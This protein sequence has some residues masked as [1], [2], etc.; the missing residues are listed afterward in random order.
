MADN[1]GILGQLSQ[2]RCIMTSET[3]PRE[4]NEPNR[5]FAHLSALASSPLPVETA[6]FPSPA[7]YIRS[8]GRVRSEEHWEV[9]RTFFAPM[10]M[11]LIPAA[12]IAQTLEVSV[13]TVG[14]WKKRL[15][16]DM[17]REAVTMQPRDFIMESIE[18]LREAR[19]EAWK[20]YYLSGTPR[21]RRAF[22]QSITQI[23]GQLGKLGAD[24]GLYGGRGDKPLS[25]A[26]HGGTDDDPTA[27]GA[28]RI[29]FF[30]EQF[31]SG[32]ATKDVAMDQGFSGNPEET[33]VSYD[34]LLAEPRPRQPETE[35]PSPTP[36]LPPGITARRRQRQPPPLLDAAP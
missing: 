31:L 20:G 10:V 24:N 22:L 35:P 21:D 8:F 26:T 14:R 23:E 11:Q 13:E 30:L 12:E 2:D 19:A 34:A 29:K 4:P 17:R 18:S 5:A 27:A 36:Q 15:F 7:A 16:A 6:L 32:A 9:I 28:K 1:A 3:A 33:R 25:L